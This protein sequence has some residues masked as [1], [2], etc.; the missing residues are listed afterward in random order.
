MLAGPRVIRPIKRMNDPYIPH[1]VEEKAQKRWE[2]EQSFVAKNDGQGTKFFCLSMFPYPSGQL[3]MGHVRNYTLGD[4][5]NRYQRMKGFNVMQPM[6]WDAFGLPA[7]NAAIKNDIPPADWTRGNISHMKSQMQRLGFGIDWSREFATCD[8]EYYRWEQWLF[9]RLYKKG[10]VYRKNSIVN[11]DPVDQTVL[12]NEQVIDG[13]GWRSG[14]LVE[15]KEMA[16]WFLKIT[17]YADEL[18]DEIENLEGWPESVKSMQRNWI[19]R[20][21]G[22]EIDFP[23]VDRDSEVLRV[24]TT[25]PDTL[26]GATYLAIAPEHSLALEAAETDPE[27]KRFVAEMRKARSR[28]PK[29]L[30]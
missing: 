7:E 5:I 26:L 17:E 10:L 2:E 9:V 21:Q 16:Q 12:A 25:R 15:R 1:E 24:F 4:V 13:R 18:L 28:L 22:V 3:H 20:S 30:G 27:I 11:W 14:E 29:N 6:G 19:G 8:P 23:V